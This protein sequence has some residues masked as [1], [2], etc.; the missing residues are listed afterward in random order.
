[1]LIVSH[2]GKKKKKK[3]EHFYLRSLVNFSLALEATL[4]R[5][6]G[7][8][9]MWLAISKLHCGEQATSLNY[10]QSTDEEGRCKAIHKHKAV[11][12]KPKGQQETHKRRE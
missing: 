3:Q 8:R 12:L 6:F 5:V 2:K 10:L 4:C 7:V 11:S 9:R 1:M